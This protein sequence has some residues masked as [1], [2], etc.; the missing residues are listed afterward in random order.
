MYYTSQPLECQHPKLLAATM[1]AIKADTQLLFSSDW[2]HWDF[3]TPS[4]V[5]DLPCLTE[6]AKRD[7]LGANAAK[8]F[9]L[10]DPY[11]ARAAAAE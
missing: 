1:E 2:P 6:K 10:K 3:D 11:A 4:A 8:L 7:I 9:G 5:W